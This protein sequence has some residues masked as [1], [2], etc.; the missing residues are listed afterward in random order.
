MGPRAASS[1]W[2][3]GVLLLCAALACAPPLPPAPTPPRVLRLL[4][5]GPPQRWGGDGGAPIALNPAALRARWPALGPALSACLGDPLALPLAGDPGAWRKLVW[6]EAPRWR[7][8]LSG[9]GG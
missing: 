6:Q 1:P 7:L 3:W 4:D 2:V 5:P 8:E 9:Q